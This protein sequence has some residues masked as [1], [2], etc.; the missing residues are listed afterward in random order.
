MSKLL[1]LSVDCAFYRMHC[2]F[3]RMPAILYRMAG[4]L[5]IPRKRNAFYIECAEQKYTKQNQQY[6]QK[7]SLFVHLLHAGILIF[8]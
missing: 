3:Y 4:I 7:S 2:A 8:E 5:G 6:L 1:A